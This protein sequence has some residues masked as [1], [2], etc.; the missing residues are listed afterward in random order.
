MYTN[1]DIIA[2]LVVLR[3]NLLTIP[4]RTHRVFVRK[5]STTDLRN[6]LVSDGTAY[7]AAGIY[8][9]EGYI[10]LDNLECSGAVRRENSQQLSRDGGMCLSERR[11]VFLKRTDE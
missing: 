9:D 10:F 6:I 5:Q 7:G 1:I 2:T 8:M 3:T 11:N 4:F